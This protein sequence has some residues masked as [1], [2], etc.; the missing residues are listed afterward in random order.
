MLVD[1][2]TGLKHKRSKHLLKESLEYIFFLIK[3]F[4]YSTLIP[5]Y[6]DKRIG[7]QLQ[8]DIYVGHQHILF[9]TLQYAPYNHLPHFLSIILSI[10]IFYIQP[11]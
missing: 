6:K 1:T 5:H 9:E 7:E 8:I 11:S 2:P 4:K 3:H 10:S